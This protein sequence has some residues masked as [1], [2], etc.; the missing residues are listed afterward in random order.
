MNVD[1]LGISELKW[2]G[3]GEFNSDPHILGQ[4]GMEEINKAQPS[5]IVMPPVFPRKPWRGRELLTHQPRQLRVSPRG[6]GRRAR[7]LMGPDGLALFVGTCVPHPH[8]AISTFVPSLRKQ[9]V[10]F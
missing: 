7:Q 9:N 6:A 4:R 5:S 10:H 1:I 3:M 8:T 2:T